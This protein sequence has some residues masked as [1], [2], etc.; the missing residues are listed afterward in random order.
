M[1]ENVMEQ[2]GTVPSIKWDYTAVAGT[3]N[4]LAAAVRCGNY[5]EHRLYDQ[6]LGD[7]LSKRDWADASPE[8][9]SACIQSVLDARR[10]Y[11]EKLERTEDAKARR[12]AK[13]T[14]G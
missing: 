10:K 7:L 6:L 13:K 4:N 3:G 2:D 9:M 5:E 1:S 11:F 8:H 14:A 12:Q